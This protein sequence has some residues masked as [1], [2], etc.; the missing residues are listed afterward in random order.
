MLGKSLFPLRSRR[1][2]AC[3]F[4]RLSITGKIA[5]YALL[6]VLC[7]GLFCFAGAAQNTQADS[8][9]ALAGQ[10]PLLRTPLV[11]ACSEYYPPFSMRNSDGEAAG[12]F[13]DIWKLWSER[14]GIPVR[15]EMGA[16]SET[17]RMMREGQAD[18]H[19]GMFALPDRAEWLLFTQPFYSIDSA[20]LVPEKTTDISGIAD[21]KGHVLGAVRDSF[22]DIWLQ[23]NFPTEQIV[24]MDNEKQLLQATL[25]KKMDAF[26]AE[27]PTAT[28]ILD[29]QGRYGDFRLLLLPELTRQVH[30]AVPRARPE[31]LRLVDKGLS[32]I[33]NEDLQELES[34]WVANPN[35]RRFPQQEKGL[36][37]TSDEEAWLASH[38]LVLTGTR[39]QTRPLEFQSSEEEHMG[40]AAEYLQLLMGRAGLRYEP[41]SLSPFSARLDAL[42]HRDVDII[43]CIMPTPSLRREFLFTEP[44]LRLPSV[45]VTRS[46]APFVSG[47]S[48]LSGHTVALPVNT[49]RVELLFRD[50]PE[51]ELSVTDNLAEALEAVSLGRA[52][53]A[54]GDLPSMAATISALGLTNLKIAGRTEYDYDEYAI[55]V[56]P[57]LPE[58]ASILDKAILSLTRAERTEIAEH[59]L[60]AQTDADMNPR[61]YWRMALRFGGAAFLVLLM[62]LFWNRRL[63]TE[64]RRRRETEKALAEAEKSYREF[65]DNVPVGIFKTGPDGRMVAANPEMLRI[66]GYDSITEGNGSV[67]THLEQWFVHQ[68]DRDQYMSTLKTQGEVKDFLHQ[69]RRKDGQEI[70]VNISSRL[71][72]GP[73]GKIA[74]VN[75]F[76]QDATKSKMAL[77]ALRKSEARL[78]AIM[79]NSPF[80][81]LTLDDNLRMDLPL[82]SPAAARITSYKLNELAQHIFVDFVHPEDALRIDYLLRR[83]LASPGENIAFECRWRCRDGN[84]RHLECTGANFKDNPDYGGV[85]LIMRDVTA[86]CEAQGRLEQAR[87]EAENANRAKSDFLASMSHE[88]RT[89]M[90]AILGM[91]EVL[92]E[93]ELS[94]EQRSYVALFRSAGENLLELINDILDLS[95]VEAGQV[96]L[97]RIPFNLRELVEKVANIMALRARKN[98]VAL[99]YAVDADVPE[100]LVGDPG[101]LRQVLANLISNAVKFTPKG[102]IDIRVRRDS[103]FDAPDCVAFVVKDTGIG[104]PPNKIKAIFESFVQADS[105]TTRRFGGTGLGLTISE[106]LVRLMGGRIW[107]ESVPGKGS[108]FHFSVP[109]AQGLEQNEEQ[110]QNEEKRLEKALPSADILV[111]EDAESNLVLLQA[112][113][114][115]TAL[116]L[117]VACNGREAL[118]KFAAR[119]YDLVLMDMQMPVMDGYE[120]TRCIRQM[121]NRKGRR[122]TP[123]L[124]LTAFALKGDAE[125]CLQA[126]CDTHIAKPVQREELL[127]ILL[128]HL[129]LSAR[130]N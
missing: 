46:D 29:R 76:L 18:I 113:L 2:S 130:K 69:A 17:L 72:Y 121:E 83:F 3:R 110:A 101:R 14:T 65:F 115:D 36:R 34:R 62:L 107:V 61:T 53:A 109:M 51:L 86:Q 13:I 108:T 60:T 64:V 49:G 91:A 19:T 9:S 88:I 57:E 81:L 97:E 122:R 52:D 58:L 41:R 7:C 56:R 68:K 125:K 25:D 123:V 15:F 71:F 26:V 33:T 93:T 6:L 95:K 40:M 10:E 120:A 38:P 105:S 99:D 59:W 23:Q 47:L 5:A 43:S 39:K 114:E 79:E 89:P 118:D 85:L 111:V 106:R 78:K 50:Y 1:N 87:Q 74:S 28:A 21:L 8:S 67:G 45:I 20:V 117:D 116:R 16:W 27:V 96:L 54:V 92:S 55:A 48:D 119:E 124:A 75:G 94:Q 128:E 37:L 98:G 112:Y 42:R 30:G 11:L 100:I 4:N 31:L 82:E 102:R 77:D 129:T 126:G 22:Q 104:I 63:N 84:W 35:L 32:K 66:S 73:D 44:Y 127:R 103:Q 24:L 70:W 12:L 80:V 90:N